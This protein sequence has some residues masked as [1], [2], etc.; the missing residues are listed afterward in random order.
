M[1]LW[2]ECLKFYTGL[3]SSLHFDFILKVRHSDKKFN[4]YRVIFFHATA[5]ISKQRLA[6]FYYAASGHIRELCIYH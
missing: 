4:Y 1:T 6:I 5:W 3:F 2:S